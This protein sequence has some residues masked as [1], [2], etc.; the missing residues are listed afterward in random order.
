MFRLKL[1]LLLNCSELHKGKMNIKFK[2][3][4]GI[5]WQMSI[6]ILKIT[7]NTH[8]IQTVVEVPNRLMDRRFYNSKRNESYFQVMKIGYTNSASKN[9]KH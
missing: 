7:C 4:P 5:Y 1:E 2:K 3:I 8:Y 9:P 6:F